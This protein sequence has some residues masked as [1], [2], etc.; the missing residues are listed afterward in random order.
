M[1]IKKIGRQLRVQNDKD[2]GRGTQ[3]MGSEYTQEEM[4]VNERK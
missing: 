3:M 1:I 4:I 2:I